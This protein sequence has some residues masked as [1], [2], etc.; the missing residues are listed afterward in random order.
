MKKLILF[1]LTCATIVSFCACSGKSTGESDASINAASSETK[2]IAQTEPAPASAK[3]ELSEREKKIF[4]AVIRLATEEFYSPAS[5]RLLEVG[6][7][8]QILFRRNEDLWAPPQVY[9]FRLQGENLVGGGNNSWFAICTEGGEFKDKEEWVEK[10]KNNT[11]PGA[12]R[13]MK[14]MCI[15][16]KKG[17]YVQL[18]DDMDIT[19][20][21]G[22]DSDTVKKINRA[23]KEYMEDM[24]FN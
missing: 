23:I 10:I 2:V 15:S 9:A 6:R 21:W 24:G 20:L 17:E 16:A 14:L 18:K 3:D 13:E 7:P 5:V 1:L 8:N 19:K 12:I 11:L 4:D 22:S